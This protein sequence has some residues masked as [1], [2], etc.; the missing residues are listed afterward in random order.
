M[1]KQ[2]CLGLSAVLLS[3]LMVRGQDVPVVQ[4]RADGSV[5]FVVVVTTRSGEPVADLGQQ[6]FA[7]FDDDVIRPIRTFR[8]IRAASKQDESHALTVVRVPNPVSSSTYELI[9]DGAKSQGRRQFHEVGIKVDRPNLE[10][11]TSAGYL[12]SA[13]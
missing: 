1:K 13:Y 3:T 11:A 10:V 9:F 8:T 2:V 5:R 6:D 12:T 4:A 7:I